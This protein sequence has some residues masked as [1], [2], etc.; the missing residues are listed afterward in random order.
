MNEVT[1]LIKEDRM[2]PLLK[3]MEDFYIDEYINSIESY[4]LTEI[5]ES[6]F[7][8]V[9]KGDLLLDAA[10]II[11]EK[12]YDYYSPFIFIEE[13]KNVIGCSSS[14]VM[15]SA[16]DFDKWFK[17]HHFDPK[18]STVII[19]GV[20][21]Q[22]LSIRNNPTHVN[23][24][25]TIAD[26]HGDIAENA[27]RLNL[28]GS[29]IYINVNELVKLNYDQINF[30]LTHESS[31]LTDLSI[32]RKTNKTI[33]N[34][35]ERPNIQELHKAIKEA[36]ENFKTDFYKYAKMSHNFNWKNISSLKDSDKKELFK[37]LEKL[38]QWVQ[39]EKPEEASKMK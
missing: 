22:V 8:D 36:P 38:D 20:K 4:D 34:L 33:S 10:E 29:P 2:N 12:A 13:L 9:L 17:D 39:K 16:E 7:N 24:T 15:E 30:Y 23:I 11:Y 6:L 31:H 21:R 18:T 37:F 14:N 3:K 32:A 28:K 5:K 35:N 19:R 1:T 25:T 26:N 27:L